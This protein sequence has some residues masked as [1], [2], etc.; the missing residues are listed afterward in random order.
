MQLK[1]RIAASLLF[2]FSFLIA[3][4]WTH[5]VL[6][7]DSHSEESDGGDADA[8]SDAGPAKPRLEDTTRKRATLETAGYI[9]SDNVAVFTPSVTA[10]VANVTSGASLTGSYLVD[11]V[12]AASPDIV[13]TASRRWQEVRQAGALSAAY[14]PHEFGLNLAASFSN[15]PDYLSYGGGGGFSKD[16]DEKNWTLSFGFG[17]SHDTIGRHGTPFSVFSREVNRGSFQGGLAWV[18]NPTTLAGIVADV[19]VE[20][21]DQS[22]PYRYIPMFAPSVAAQA[23]L[24]ASLDWVTANRLPERP[25]EQLPLTRRRFALSLRLAHRFDFSTLKLDERLYLDT[26]AL[27]ASTTDARWTFDVGKRFSFGPHARFH[28]QKGVAFWQRAYAAAPAPQWNLPEFR[29]GDREEGPLWTVT[30]GLGTAVYLG[31]SSEPSSWALKL[32]FDGMY[33]SFLD[34]IYVSSR[35]GAIGTLSVEAEL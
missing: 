25:L 24:G 1:R 31:G 2:A 8:E 7:D 21:G 14:K 28:V 23:P 27:F 4:A 20:N 3:L 5:R 17:Y 34:D 16:F 29:T 10:S 26:W 13:A 12:S 22:K 19:V 33:T 35:S 9:D 18:V 11:I 6:G 15:E 30:G 32:Q